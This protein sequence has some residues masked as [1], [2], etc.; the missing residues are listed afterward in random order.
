MLRGEK[1]L[2]FKKG[3][4]ECSLYRLLVSKGAR[5]YGLA[6]TIID[7]RNPFCAF[8][9]LFFFFLFYSFLSQAT[10]VYLGRY[11]E[12]SADTGFSLYLSGT[13]FREQLPLPV[14][15]FAL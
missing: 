13:L 15:V 5:C 10:R 12:S 4:E 2:E 8:F 7:E 14:E 9:L 11:V 6:C 3:K 1:G